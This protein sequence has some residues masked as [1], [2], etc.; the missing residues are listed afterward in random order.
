M[1]HPNMQNKTTRTWNIWIKV[2]FWLNC[3]VFLLSLFVGLD[4]PAFLAM[5][6]SLLFIFWFAL[7]DNNSFLFK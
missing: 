4:K 6:A 5:I 2:L 3:S 7:K 1:L